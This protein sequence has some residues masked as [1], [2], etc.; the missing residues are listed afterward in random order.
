[1][2]S[3]FLTFL[4]L[5]AATTMFAQAPDLMSYQAVVRN[6]TNALVTS[7]PVGVQISILQ[8]S[9]TGI[10]VYIERH[11][12]TTNANGLATFEIGNGTVVAGSFS[13]IDWANGPYYLKTETDPTG[14]T[15]YTISATTQLLS[16]PYA[17]YAGNGFSGDYND[18]TNAPTNVS[19]FTND[20]GYITSPNDADSDPTNEIQT[21]SINGSDLTISGTGGNTVTLPA[22]GGNTL[23][24][25]YDQGGAGAGRVI[26]ADAGEVEIVHSAAN[27]IGLR[28]TTSNT[29][30]GVLSTSTSSA[31][32]YSPIQATTNSST[33]TTSAIIGSSSGAA[34]GVSGQVESVGTA[35]AGIYGNNLRTTGGHG[36]YGIGF[37]GLVGETNY[38]QGFAVYGYNYDAITPLGNAVGTYGRGYVGV[39]GD[40]NTT[41]AYAVYANG[42]LGAVGTKTFSIDHPTDPENKY[43]R[44]FSIESDEVLNVYRGNA[45]FDEN[46]EAVVVMPDYFSAV[47]NEN[48]TYQLTPI[49]GYAPLYIKQKMENGQ[50]V[51]AGGT[52]G[53]EVSWTV[54][55]ER[56]DPYMQQH[57]EKRE[58][59]VEKEAWN[60]GLY[61]RPDLYGQPEEKKIV[62]PLDTTVE[63]QQQ[64]LLE[65]ETDER[66]E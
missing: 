42:D 24:Q 23:D 18:L 28:T 5:F 32:T 4:G 15:T 64:Q 1:M 9:P 29:G 44:H 53:M 40:V 63:Q 10:A 8:S 60:K 34:N 36:V 65:E 66:E 14:G 16:V 37:N 22:G 56:N 2:K 51:I 48:C 47:S 54:H 30:V 52:D 6:S 39:W 12:P 46:G 35:Q 55:T 27:S 58:V 19:S 61:L 17:L 43:L 49:G 45:S 33:T 26:T 50:F 7:S 38:S 25:A 13:G 57:P 59:E 3:I 20:A 31:N 41:N 21:L 62:R 11:T